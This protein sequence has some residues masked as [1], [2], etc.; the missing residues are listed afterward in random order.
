[1]SI[2]PHQIDPVTAGWTPQRKSFANR[3][4]CLIYIRSFGNYLAVN[5]RSHRSVINAAAQLSTP[6]TLSEKRSILSVECFSD[7]P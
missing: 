7:R 3:V 2:A 5:L 1:M 4:T 6:R